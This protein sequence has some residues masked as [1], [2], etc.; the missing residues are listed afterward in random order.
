M[1]RL[2][3]NFLKVAVYTPDDLPDPVQLGGLP[4]P[5]VKKNWRLHFARH[6]PERLL[7]QCDN[8]K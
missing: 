5:N 6:E 7:I 3:E 1:G 4:F 2:F 8:N